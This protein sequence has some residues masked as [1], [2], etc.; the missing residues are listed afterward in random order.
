LLEE[1]RQQPDD[2][3]QNTEAFCETGQ[4]D[5]QAADL[6]G[7]VWVSADRVARQ[8]GQDADAD[9]GPDDAKAARPAPICSVAIC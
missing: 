8:A 5:R 6:A 3:R 7:G 1:E 9:P 2:D 4:D